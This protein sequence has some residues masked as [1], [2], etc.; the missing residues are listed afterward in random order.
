MAT[1]ESKRYDYT[2][3]ALTAL[4]GANIGSGTFAQARI[5]SASVT[6]HVDLTTLNA[7]NLTSGTIPNARYGTPT[8][9]GTNITSVG[10]GVATSIGVV[11]SYAAVTGT[12]NSGTFNAD[13]AGNNL[14]YS[15][16]DSHSHS[17][18]QESNGTSALSG[19]WRISGGGIQ[20]ADTNYG[21]GSIAGRK[22]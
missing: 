16:L 14:R 19:T 3:A 21:R 12:V 7:S 13:V 6:Q 22:C 9:S 18:W 1:Y 15:A 8:F 5:A 17:K 20:V 2:G 4:N 10:V 11:N